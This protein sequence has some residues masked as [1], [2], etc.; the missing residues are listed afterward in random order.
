MSK[1]RENL[2]QTSRVNLL[3]GRQGDEHGSLHNPGQ[4]AAVHYI[5]LKL[6]KVCPK[7]KAAKPLLFTVL[8]T[9]TENS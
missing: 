5:T 2:L 1:F 4:T 3:V 6:F 7:Y 9:E 8:K